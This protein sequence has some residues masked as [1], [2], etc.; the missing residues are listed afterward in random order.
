MP[1]HRDVPT[2]LLRNEV[3]PQLA[4]RLREQLE[5][6]ISAEGP[7]DALGAI[8]SLRRELIGWKEACEAA[9][10]VNQWRRDNRP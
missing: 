7:D 9:I 1:N 3:S 5:R 8:Q 10:R 2:D 4:S 6:A